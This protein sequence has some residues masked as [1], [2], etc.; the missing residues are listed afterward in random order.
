MSEG[1]CSIILPPQKRVVEKPQ[2]RSRHP[3]FDLTNREALVF[4]RQRDGDYMFRKPSKP[5]SYAEM[6]EK[7]RKDFPQPFFKGNKGDFYGLCFGFVGA[8]DA[9]E[10]EW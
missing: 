3:S 4:I 1:L 8:K 7:L 5:K 10:G 9:L 2:E 6:R